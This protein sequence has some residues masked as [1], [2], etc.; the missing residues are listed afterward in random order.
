VGRRSSRRRSGLEDGFR[1]IGRVSI[2]QRRSRGDPDAERLYHA[3]RRAVLNEYVATLDRLKLDGFVYPAIQMPPP[4]ETMPQDG[5]L[6]DG[7]HSATSWVNMI[8]VPAM[9]VPPDSTTAVFRSASRFRGVRG[10]T[11]PC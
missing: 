5:H 9:V 4:D 6:S 2:E 10:L 8:G 1:N 7:P 3:P 11:A